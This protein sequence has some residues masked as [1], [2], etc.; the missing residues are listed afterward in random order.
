[1]A[2]VGQVELQQP[3]VELEVILCFQPLHLLVAVEVVAVQEV[4]QIT[5]ETMVVPV[6]VVRHLLA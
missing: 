4:A 5:M 1:L 3:K 2:L 6:V